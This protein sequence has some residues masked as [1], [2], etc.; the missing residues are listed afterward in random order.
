MASRSNANLAVLAIATLVAHDVRAQSAASAQDLYDKG[1]ELMKAKKFDEACAAFEESQRLV[2]A[3]TTQLAIAA[4]HETAGR[5]ATAYGMYVELERGVRDSTVATEQ[6]L[7]QQAKTKAASL[8]PR[9]SR[10]SVTVAPDVGIEGLEIKR[11]SIVVERGQWNTALPID[12]GTYT[13]SA[14][15]SGFQPWE[16][17]VTV[18]NERD[19]TKVV[20]VPSLVKVEAPPPPPPDPVVT[21]T[22]TDSTQ[23]PS[24][25][26]PAG[27]TVATPTPAHSPA[28]PEPPLHASRG[29]SS[30]LPFIVGGGAL[31]LGGA[32]LGSE[33]WARSSYDMA[34]SPTA[35]PA[36]QLDLWESANKRRHIA[37]GF[38]V[39]SLVTAGV[40]VWLYVRSRSD[41]A[42][43]PSGG[44]VMAPAVS[45]D[46]IGLVVQGS[47]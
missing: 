2:A 12:G 19:T 9:L 6:S 34:T 23:K 33:L 25:P 4:C 11:G 30:R 24:E 41:D 26:P 40:G 38:G 7:H 35:M 47:Y 36:R 21:P 18:A 16:T 5:L 13:Y 27:P 28:Q 3:R 43:S 39:A 31:L 45:S 42:R 44:V 14:T 15:A 22:T 37:Q 32:A 46:N 20:T 1:R 8:K 29:G 17:K 10:I